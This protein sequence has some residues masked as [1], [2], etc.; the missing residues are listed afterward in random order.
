M[1]FPRQLAPTVGPAR[2]GVEILGG[3]LQGMD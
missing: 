3:A 1:T 2:A